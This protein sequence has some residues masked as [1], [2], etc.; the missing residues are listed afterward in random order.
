MSEKAAVILIVVSQV[1]IIACTLR[2][3]YLYRCLKREN[4][5][6]RVMHYGHR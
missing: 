1:V 5:Y 3:L 6:L 2:L 4:E